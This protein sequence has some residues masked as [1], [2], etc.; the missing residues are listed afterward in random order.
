M[1]KEYNHLVDTNYKVMGNEYIAQKVQQGY[2]VPIEIY[3]TAHSRSTK[4]IY[5]MIDQYLTRQ[6]AAR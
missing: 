4:I 5:N 2:E 1:Q 3:S 6:E